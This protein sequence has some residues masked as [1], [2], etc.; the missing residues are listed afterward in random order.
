MW[1]KCDLC[2]YIC[3]QMYFNVH[4]SVIEFNDQITTFGH[5]IMLSNT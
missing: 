1:M 5:V 4:E 3:T 2:N